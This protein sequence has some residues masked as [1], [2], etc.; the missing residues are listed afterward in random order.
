MSPSTII[1][2]LSFFIQLCGMST[3]TE[4]IAELK[5]RPEGGEKVD[6]AVSIRIK[7]SL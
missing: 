4:K 1:P 6:R 7:G 2:C 3:G 5:I